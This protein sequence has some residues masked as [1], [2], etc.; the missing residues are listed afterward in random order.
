MNI[1]DNYLALNGNALTVR[2]ERI[3]LIAK[4]IAN[5][6]TPNF[7]AKDIDFAK[8]MAKFQA[9]EKNLVVTDD[10]HIGIPKNFGTSTD[11][12]LVYR[13]PLSP[14]LDNNTVEL[15]IEQ[16]NYGKAAAQYQASLQFLEGRI[17]GL[18]KALRG[19]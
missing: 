9:P 4:N 8:A 18:R 17:S 12:A 16:A 15:S 5:A 7:K 2:N 14:S 1:L 10:L 3:Q 13:V 6:S 11:D 19:D